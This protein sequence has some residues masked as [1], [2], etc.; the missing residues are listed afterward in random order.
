MN[1]T[2]PTHEEHVREYMERMMFALERIA[3]VSL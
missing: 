1:Y 2:P 3:N